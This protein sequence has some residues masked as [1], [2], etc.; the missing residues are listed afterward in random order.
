MSGIVGAVG[1]GLPDDE[2]L[3]AVQ[4]GCAAQRPESPDSSGT[5]LDD[6]A[7]IGNVRS[8]IPDLDDGA[9][10]YVA[11][12]GSV[13]AY[14]GEAFLQEWD[15]RSDTCSLEEAW[16]TQ[17]LSLLGK[18]GA[19]SA[20]AAWDPEAGGLTLVRDPLG[21][22]PLFF[23]PL[24]GGGLAFA[25]EPKGLRG[26]P[27]VDWTIRRPAIAEFLAGSYLSGP[28]TA[29][30][31]VWRLPPGS[32]LTWR[33]G[34][35]AWRPTAGLRTPLAPDPMS[36][37]SLA[38]LWPRLL[39][40]VTRRL[41]GD[42]PVGLLLSGGLDSS[43]VAAA[44]TSLAG[45][46]PAWTIRWQEVDYDESG[47]AADVATHL[48]LDH[49]LVDC[50]ATDLP[51]HLDELSTAYDEPFADESMLP[52]L[53]VCRAA[54]R[55]VRAV[56]TGDGGDEAF[57]G[58]E[59]YAYPDCGLDEYLDVFQAASRATVSTVLGNR[60]H[61]CDPWSA[62]RP[63]FSNERET[64]PLLRRRR[65]DVHTY[66][67]DDILTKI[68]R[69]ARRSSIT[70]RAPFLD[71]DLFSWAMSL[72]CGALVDRGVQKALLRHAAQGR[73]PSDVLTR[74]KQGFGVPIRA[75][76]RGPLLAWLE[77]SLLAGCLAE[78]GWCDGGALQKVMDEHA[79]GETDH[80]RLL[81]NLVVLERW[82]RRESNPP[83]PVPMPED[84][85][86]RDA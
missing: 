38:S 50:C 68:D 44:A 26:W 19:L 43:M 72:P 64:S 16:R 39:E 48:G 18:L 86:S 14:D 70:A 76:F 5:Y 8:A 69:V 30:R 55:E 35:T 79:S 41:A 47:H 73:L 6:R 53:L 3:Q 40:A 60:G 36:P 13:L 51:L 65:L 12:D 46:L 2:A 32:C 49:T 25:S 81:L 57:G 9:Q 63:W 10:P 42:R 15:P 83:A 29:W 66:L 31:G 61:S 45:P 54:A 21:R 80:A 4:A 22:S 1:H 27:G 75:W 67:P 23:A 74:P 52:T 20:F 56:L 24:P 82:L 33:G 58:Y 37:C 77:E 62:Y 71:R 28:R 34:L 11:A 84:P 78:S 7:A 17:G 59:R 85:P